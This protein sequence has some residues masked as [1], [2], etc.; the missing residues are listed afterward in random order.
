M[1][2]AERLA[3]SQKLTMVTEKTFALLCLW[4][5]LK[6]WQNPFFS[7]WQYLPRSVVLILLFNLS[8][9]LLSLVIDVV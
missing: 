1:S 6:Q 5:Q 2:D 3:I 7:L 8:L 9:L 4:T